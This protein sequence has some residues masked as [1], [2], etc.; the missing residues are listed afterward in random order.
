MSGSISTCA[1]SSIMI[2]LRCVLLIGL[3]IYTLYVPWA[4]LKVF[5]KARTWL[6]SLTVIDSINGGMGPL[7]L[8]GAYGDSFEE[9]FLKGEENDNHRYRRQGRGGHNVRISHR[10]Q[11]LEIA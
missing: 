4:I 11:F 6:N 1:Q 10:V 7:S 2:W 8:D 9:V 5:F 3:L